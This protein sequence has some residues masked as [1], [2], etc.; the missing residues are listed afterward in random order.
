MKIKIGLI[1]RYSL[2]ATLI[3]VLVVIFVLGLFFYQNIYTTVTTSSVILELQRETAIVEPLDVVNWN[4]IKEF[5]KKR[6]ELKSLDLSTIR[7][8]FID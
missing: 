5:L 6:D 3:L 8:P 4:K 1:Y 7:N 2:M